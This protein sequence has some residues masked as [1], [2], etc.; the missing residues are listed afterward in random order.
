MKIAVN[1]D[2]SMLLNMFIRAAKEQ[3]HQIFVAKVDNVLFE[4]IEA[5]DVDAFV[6]SESSL[7]FKKAT[8]FIKKNDP[9][10]PIIAIKNSHE[11]KMNVPADIYMQE[12]MNFEGDDDCFVFA[13]IAIYNLETYIKIFATLKKLTTKVYDKI[14]FGNCVYDPTRRLLLYKDKEI[15]KLSQ[16]EGGILEILASNYGKIVKKEVIL[17]KVW[18]KSDYFVSRSMDVYV[19][20]LRN[21][22]KNNEIDIHIKNISGIGL[23][24]E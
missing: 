5:C 1:T 8:E 21:I 4:H 24:L 9:Y 7:Y 22:F 13:K 15:K 16:K 2:N 11:L 10:I 19:T 6:L 14:E 3:S 12:P 20:Y 18:R 17:E 23:T